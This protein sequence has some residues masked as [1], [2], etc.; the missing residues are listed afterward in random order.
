MLIAV[1]ISLA[2]LVLFN[3]GVS[4]RVLTHD[5]LTRH[6]KAV[7]FLIIWLFPVIGASLV[8][9][10]VFARPSQSRHPGF[11]PVDQDSTPIGS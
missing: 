8:L 2:V 1:M 4:A 5:G 3:A 6:Q 9:L 11:D 10:I 7:Q